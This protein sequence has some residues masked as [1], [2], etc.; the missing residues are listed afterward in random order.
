MKAAMPNLTEIPASHYKDLRD[1]D[2]KDLP[3]LAGARFNCTQCHAP[4]SE[5]EPTVENK[6][7]PDFQSDAEKNSSNLAET[8]NIG[9]DTIKE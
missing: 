8:L 4:Q 7:T 5:I 2:Q 6:F 1:E 9:N 3:K